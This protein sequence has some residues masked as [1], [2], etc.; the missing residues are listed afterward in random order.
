MDSKGTAMRMP[1]KILVPVDFSAGAM[2]ALEY[3]TG[4]AAR[5]P[6]AEITIMH[7][8]EP[9]V[10]P[11]APARGAGRAGNDA[12]RKEVETRLKALGEKAR[13][14]SKRR[15]RTLV[16][17]GRAYQEI[18]RAAADADLVVIGSA[19]YTAQ[20]YSQFGITAERVARKAPCPVLL[21]RDAGK[22]G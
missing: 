14:G 19:G 7:A 12:W 4:L 8:I 6:S 5:L 10:F 13:A 20:D 3:A 2:K 21:V 18:A 1:K 22:A 9:M 15:I 11:V 17:S 16:R